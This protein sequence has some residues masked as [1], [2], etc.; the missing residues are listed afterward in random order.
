MAQV[1]GV[2]S[3]TNITIKNEDTYK[4]SEGYSGN[5]FDILGATENNIV[6]PSL[7]P[8]IFEIKYPLKDIVGSVEGSEQGGL[9]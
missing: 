4:V 8:S 9:Y 2:S 6:Y 7:D 5:A 1:D 3:V